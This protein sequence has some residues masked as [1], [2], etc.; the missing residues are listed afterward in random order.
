VHKA[1]PAASQQRELSMMSL[2]VWENNAGYCPVFFIGRIN[3]GK[4][5]EEEEKPWT[6][7]K[8]HI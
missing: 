3:N 2:V 5:W 4:V 7:V 8:K 6:Y 1:L